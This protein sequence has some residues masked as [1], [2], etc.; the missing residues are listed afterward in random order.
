[1]WSKQIHETRLG[2]S[3]VKATSKLAPSFVFETLIF[4]TKRELSL[5]FGGCGTKDVAM[6]THSNVTIP[7]TNNK[8]RWRSTSFAVNR[9]VIDRDMLGF[10]IEGLNET[11]SSGIVAERCA[12]LLES[13]VNR[14][15]CL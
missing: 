5:I 9:D 7:N 6:A 3:I 8:I 13:M 4:D 15:L 12:V 11:G 1:M 2:F 10:E 14:N